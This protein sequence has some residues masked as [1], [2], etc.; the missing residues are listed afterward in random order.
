M[1]KPPEL[2]LEAFTVHT[3]LGRRTYRWSWIYYYW[4][5]PRRLELLL[6]APELGRMGAVPAIHRDHVPE[7]L[8]YPSF[9]RW[10]IN[11][12]RAVQYGLTRTEAESYGPPL[13]TKW[14]PGCLPKAAE[15]NAESASQDMPGQGYDFLLWVDRVGTFSKAAVFAF[16]DDL[17]T[18]PWSQLG[19]SPKLTEAEGGVAFHLGRTEKHAVEAYFVTTD[20]A[21]AILSVPEAREV[22]VTPELAKTLGLR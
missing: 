14:T 13:D 12:R 7:M 4:P 21:C 18:V 19:V 17:R 22:P 6:D 15:S 8:R 16:Q 5:W 9:P 10:L 20:Q 2:S 3:L 1:A 11:A